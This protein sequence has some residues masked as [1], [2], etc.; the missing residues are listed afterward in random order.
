MSIGVKML[1]LQGFHRNR[2]ILNLN[3]RK[4]KFTLYLF[5]YFIGKRACSK[6]GD[7]RLSLYPPTVHRL[8][9]IDYG[10]DRAAFPSFF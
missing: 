7:S 8:L 1:K 3:I 9:D 4:Y 5:L 2:K 6:D 10:I